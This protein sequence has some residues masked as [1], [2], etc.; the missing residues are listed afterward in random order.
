MADL[1][2]SIF[3]IIK[4]GKAGDP[5]FLLAAVH[6]AS[7]SVLIIFCTI[8]YGDNGWSNFWNGLLFNNGFDR[9]Y[10]EGNLRIVI[11]FWQG[12]F[13]YAVMCA[14]IS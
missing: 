14:A 9:T 10:P 2:R 6:A 7:C 12:F 5:I 11:L 13:A 8:G 1:I 4:L 3:D